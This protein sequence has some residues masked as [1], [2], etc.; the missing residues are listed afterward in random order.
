MNLNKIPYGSN[1]VKYKDVHVGGFSANTWYY[2]DVAQDADLTDKDILGAFFS[3][4]VSNTFVN[5]STVYNSVNKR[6]YYGA[7]GSPTDAT[8]RIIYKT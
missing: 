8:L 7:S 3:Y 5:V 6:F 4:F 1:E 2:Y